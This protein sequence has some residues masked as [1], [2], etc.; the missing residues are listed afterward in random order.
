MK[1]KYIVC[2]EVDGLN[3]LRIRSSGGNTV[4]S[5]KFHVTVN[6]TEEDTSAKDQ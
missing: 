5:R 1:L 6:F 3:C 2:R 4:K